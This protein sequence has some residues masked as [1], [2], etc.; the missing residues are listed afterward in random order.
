MLPIAII[1][2]LDGTLCNCT[3]RRYF[4]DEKSPDW[5]S[6]YESMVM[7]TVN[8]WCL[9]IVQA[10][11]AQGNQIIFMSGRS[12]KYRP[13]TE[14]WLLKYK[15]P[16]HT[17]LYMRKEGDHRKD[18]IVKKELYEQHILG[19]YQVL[20]CIDDRNSVVNL[21]RSLGLVCLQCADGNF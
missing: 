9:D 14:D 21:W 15:I 16:K 17:G 7:D 11:Y 6:F 3:H 10:M 8:E 1:V 13:H 19:Q 5:R 2:D 4:L 12:D 20:F 18:G